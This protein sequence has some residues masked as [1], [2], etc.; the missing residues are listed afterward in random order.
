[1]SSTG[2]TTLS[3]HVMHS[4]MKEVAALVKDPPEDIKVELNEADITNICAEIVGP[5]G[6]P[7]EGGLFRMKL[8]LGADF[9]SAPPK[10][11]FLT[12][13]FHPNVS[14]TGEICVDTLKRD[15][16][17]ELGIKHLLLTI[18]CLLI[19][20]NPESALNEEA[21]RQLLEEYDEYAKHARLWTEIH[22]PMP[23]G[24]K[25]G[26]AEGLLK[27]GSK[28]A[29]QKPSSAT[30]AG[31][32]EGGALPTEAGDAKLAGRKKTAEEKKLE[33]RKNEKKKS[34]KRL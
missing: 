14:K 3:P 18:K 6:T 20:P 28:D 7:Y 22:A 4:V 26:G 21:G 12:K 25:K 8:V 13:M 29:N 9:P 31:G 5:S 15:W 10:G 32:G 2:S 24:R 17:P 33:K 27:R 19:Y 30:A 34:L 1:M 23:A 16:K 11:F